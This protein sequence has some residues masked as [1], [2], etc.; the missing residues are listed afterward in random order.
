MVLG[1]LF[2]LLPEKIQAQENRLLPTSDSAYEY[3]VRLQ[4]RGYLLGLNP[5]AL[6]YRRG[7]IRDALSRVDTTRLNSSERHWVNLLHRKLK[8]TKKPDYHGRIGYSFMLGSDVI[9]SDRMDPVRP[10]GDAINFYWHGSVANA[11]LEAGPAVAELSLF[12]SRYYDQDPDGLDSAL[13]LQARSEHSY[14]G[15]HQRW[16]SA[17]IGRWDLH[18]STPE[19][20]S[21]I[22]SDNA[23]SRDQILLRIGGNRASITAVLGELDSATDGRYYTGRA[24]DDS[25]QFGSTRRFHAAHRWDYRPTKKFMISFMESAIYSGTSSSISLKYLNPVNPFTFVVDNAPK[26]DDNNG[27]LAG[28]IWAQFKRLTLQGQF[29]IDDIRLQANTGPE[30]ITFA[31]TGSAVYAL[32]QADIKLTL[33]TVT[34]RAYNAPQTE[35][36]YI[37]LNRGIATQFSDYVHTSLFAEFYMDRRVPGLRFGPQLDLLLQGERDMRQ[38]FPL[39]SESIRNLLDGDV[40]RTVRSS[41][42][43]TYQPTHWWW[44]AVDG[45]YNLNSDHDH[46]FVGLIN[47]GIMLSLGKS[48]KL[49]DW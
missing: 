33:E 11:Y 13:R 46:R 41:V 21:T 49:W 34:A 37:Y 35:G 14:V 29:M 36:Q 1:S 9:N 18:W 7:D 4:R 38:P 25:V 42:K 12:H 17:Y 45:G 28:L 23:R 26:N 47:A 27:F 48:I 15:W 32:P 40:E 16:F 3:I 2:L 31:L 20:V 19:D 22:V 6:P 39:N 44:I 30:T 24:A 43:L 10:K 8:P 5:T